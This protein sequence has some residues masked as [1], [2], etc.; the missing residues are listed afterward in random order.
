MAIRN[1][2]LPLA[3][4]AVL[5]LSACASQGERRPIYRELGGT[6]GIEAIVDGM[7][8]RMSGDSRINHQF[9]NTDIIRF[10]RLLVELICEESGGPCRY[11]GFPMREAHANR[12]VTE[13]DF[14]AL[15]EHLIESL[16]EQGVP[17]PAQNRLLA[18]LVPMR[19]DVVRR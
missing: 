19:P 9:A 5:A 15:V 14:N 8:W 13:A 6:A 3:L 18:R 10:R 16:E 4:G 7:L 11:S 2:L 17:L 1:R 12:N